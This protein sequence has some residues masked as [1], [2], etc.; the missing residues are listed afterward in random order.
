[1]V[2]LRKLLGDRSEV[3][4][5]CMYTKHKTQKRKVWHDGFLSLHVASRKLVLYEDQPP[6]G[7]VLD[8]AKMSVYD[9][10]RRDEEY[11]NVTKFLIEVVNETPLDISTSGASSSAT[12]GFTMDEP[13]RTDPYESASA[14]AMP[15]PRPMNSKFRVPVSSGAGPPS[16]PRPG[17]RQ[18]LRGARSGGPSMGTPADIFDFSRNPTSEWAYTPHAINRSVDEVAALFQSR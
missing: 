15:P 17:M 9:W 14:A 1:M 16:A 7:K 4:Y 11:I 13:Q 10:D 8:E 2:T 6:E 18:P 3:Y 12:G 5:E